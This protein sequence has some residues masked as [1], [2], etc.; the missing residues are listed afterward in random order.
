[1]TTGN[2]GHDFGGVADN[3]GLGP[4]L[5]V[6]KDAVERLSIETHGTGDQ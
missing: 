4:S 3:Y 6:R 1:M 5:R 2:F